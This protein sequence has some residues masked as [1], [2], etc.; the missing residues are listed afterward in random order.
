MNSFLC[1]VT[2][3][4]LFEWPR[5]GA[6][7]AAI[8]KLEQASMGACERPKIKVKVTGFRL[9]GRND[10]RETGEGEKGRAWWIRG[11]QGAGRG[12]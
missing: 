3:L 2:H 8:K 5:K 11:A 9:V 1:Q 12:A 6:A 7:P 10:G 4:S